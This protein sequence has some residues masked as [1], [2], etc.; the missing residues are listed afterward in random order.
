MLPGDG[1]KQWPRRLSYITRHTLWLFLFNT[2]AFSFFFVALLVLLCGLSKCFSKVKRLNIGK[3]LLHFFAASGIANFFFFF[4]TKQNKSGK[5]PL[6]SLNVGGQDVTAENVIILSRMLQSL[7]FSVIE[8]A[9]VCWHFCPLLS[10]YCPTQG[11]IKRECHNISALHAKR[12]SSVFMN[13]IFSGSCKSRV[14]GCVSSS[15]CALEAE[16]EK[17]FLTHDHINTL[18]KNHYLCLAQTLPQGQ[19]ADKMWPLLFNFRT[20]ALFYRHVAFSYLYW[21]T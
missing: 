19:V 12:R 3:L 5:N 18:S 2:K 7:M 20:A 8:F 1:Y 11:I 13:E 9:D 21:S 16:L 10:Q 14:H 6:D 15:W 17:A 4:Y